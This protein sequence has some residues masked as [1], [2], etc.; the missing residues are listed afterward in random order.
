M[1]YILQFAIFIF[2]VT[3]SLAQVIEHPVPPP[4]PLPLPPAAEEVFKVVEEMPRF[5]GCEHIKGNSKKI[6]N[7][8][9]ETM[10]EYIY[11]NLIYPKEA[12]DNEVE[13]VAV[14]QF[15]IQKTGSITGIKIVRNP[16]AGTGEEALRIVE[17]MKKMEKKWRPGHQRGKPA[18]VQYTLPI[19]F[20]LEK[21]SRKRLRDPFNPAN[22]IVDVRSLHEEPLFPDCPKQKDSDCTSASLQEFIEENQLY[23]EEALE[24][25]IQGIVNVCFIIELDGS[26]SDIKAYGGVSKMLRDD[27]V[28]IF[29]W[30]NHEE[31]RWTPGKKNKRVVRTK[32]RCDVAYDLAEWKGRN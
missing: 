18:N 28:E 25:K 19:K 29:K 9:K 8:A 13:G 23:P 2:T 27:A 20:K 17:F 6:E 1:K 11:D 7:C 10:M 14:V 4:P 24:K 3:Q 12:L 26:L 22:D 30:M 31:M 16:G 5:P 21:P 15:V 32:Y